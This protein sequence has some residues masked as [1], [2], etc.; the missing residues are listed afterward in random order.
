MRT[1]ASGSTP[2]LSGSISGPSPMTNTSR[3]VIFIHKPP[4]H[5]LYR[6]NSTRLQCLYALRVANLSVLRP[7]R[8]HVRV[9]CGRRAAEAR[10]T[11]GVHTGRAAVGAGR[12]GEGAHRRGPVRPRGARS[13]G[14]FAQPG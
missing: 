10:T 5:L 6:T 12:E 4:R 8:A 13:E 7:R 14:A 9:E 11:P 2:P 3:A 1:H